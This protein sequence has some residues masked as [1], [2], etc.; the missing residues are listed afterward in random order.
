MSETRTGNS[1]SDPAFRSQIF[2][3][4][5]Y[6]IMTDSP[7]DVERKHIR[8]HANMITIDRPDSSQVYENAS[9]CKTIRVTRV[10]E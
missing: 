8:S 1:S 9:V 4:L 6:S 3:Y 7:I 5:T 10:L 2:Q